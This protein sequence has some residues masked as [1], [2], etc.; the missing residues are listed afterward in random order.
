MIQSRFALNFCRTIGLKNYKGR[1]NRREQRLN[2][3]NLTT[4]C[5][6]KIN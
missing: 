4:R 6:R 1:S 5:Q 3:Q 2:K